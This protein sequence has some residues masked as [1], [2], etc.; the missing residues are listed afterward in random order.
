MKGKADGGT[1]E[2]IIDDENGI[3]VSALIRQY[4]TSARLIGAFKHFTGPEKGHWESV[5]DSV[6]R[7]TARYTNE[8]E[9]R[10]IVTRK[11]VRKWRRLMGNDV[12]LERGMLDGIGEFFPGWSKGIAPMVEGRIK[13]LGAQT[14]EVHTNCGQTNGN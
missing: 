9:R 2:A 7:H 10:D 13:V 14:H 3:L 5:I 8:Q 6:G 4:F 11:V 1:A 12:D